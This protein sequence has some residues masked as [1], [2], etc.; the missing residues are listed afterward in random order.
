MKIP[1]ISLATTL[2]LGALLTVAP[3]S[4]AQ[5]KPAAPPASRPAQGQRPGQA[6]QLK[7][8]KEQLKLTDAQVEK[9]RPILKEQADKLRALRD[10]TSLS[11]QDRRKKV[12]E[13]REAT[14]PKINAIL[15]KEQSDQWEKIRQERQG[16]GQRRPGNQGRPPRP[17]Q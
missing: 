14:T 1:R 7:Q 16:Q 11:Q 15:T 2:A 6:D 13:I 4:L 17:P 5:E 3:T 10:D 9:L 12:Q 8:L